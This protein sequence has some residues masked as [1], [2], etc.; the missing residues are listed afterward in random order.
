MSTPPTRSKSTNKQLS[1]R[2]SIIHNTLTQNRTELTVAALE[3]FLGQM[4][5]L[6]SLLALVPPTRTDSA[7][8]EKKER[9]G[10]KEGRPIPYPKGRKYMP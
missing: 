3:D 2:S 7:F 9:L 8:N 5:V 6:R 4:P 10:R 1:F